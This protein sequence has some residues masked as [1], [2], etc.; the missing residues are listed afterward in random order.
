MSNP[1]LATSS[2]IHPLLLLVRPTS[3]GIIPQAN[4]THKHL[5][6]T[7]RRLSLLAVTQNYT[8]R[9]K[10]YIQSRDQELLMENKIHFRAMTRL[11]RRSSRRKLC[12]CL[13]S[14]EATFGTTSRR[15]AHNI[16][17]WLLWP[18]WKTVVIF[19]C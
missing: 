14:C 13:L 18:L 10:I 11:M 16:I 9:P 3:E 5:H 19:G 2:I 12:T 6:N 7:M 15:A 4:H 8:P 17:S 1:C